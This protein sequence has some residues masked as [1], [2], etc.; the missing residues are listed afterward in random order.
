MTL[1]KLHPDFDIA[2][3][4]ILQLDPSGHIIL[5][6]DRSIKEWKLSLVRRFQKTIDPSLQSRIHFLPWIVDG[7]VFSALLAT[8]DVI[9][10]SFHFGIGTTTIMTCA[11]GTPFVTK[12]GRF[13]R[14]RGGLW[15]CKL[16]D[17]EE[18]I[19]VDTEDYA[20]KAVLIATNQNVRA[21]ETLHNPS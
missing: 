20:Q 7:E 15:C 19:A 11:V 4:R 21:R 10:D 3:D 16:L 6:E 17:V 14:G 1:Q 9:L 13:L 2:L 12:P 18:C 5:F 8:A